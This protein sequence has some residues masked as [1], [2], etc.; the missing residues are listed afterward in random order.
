V[1][2]DEVAAR[3]ELPLLTVTHA[4]RADQLFTKSIAMVEAVEKVHPDKPLYPAQREERRSERALMELGRG[5]QIRS[6]A[7]THAQDFVENDYAKNRLRLRLGLVETCLTDAPDILGRFLSNAGVV[8]APTLWRIFLVD[9]KF[10]TYL[11]SG[12]PLL[13]D[14]G[15]RLISHPSVQ[16]VLDKE[17]E[18]IYYDILEARGVPLIL[19]LDAAILQKFLGEHS[20]KPSSG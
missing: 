8:F 9:R 16:Q 7:V 17:L 12:L 13:S 19:K 4:G 5:L 11:L 18:K 10:E 15:R 1:A 2:P 3:Q 20:S 14:W 6:S